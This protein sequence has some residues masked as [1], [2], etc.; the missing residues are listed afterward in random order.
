MHILLLK[1]TDALRLKAEDMSARVLTP[2]F[3]TGAFVSYKPVKDKYNQCVHSHE[4]TCTCMFTYSFIYYVF[5]L[6]VFH[7]VRLGHIWDGRGFI[8]KTNKKKN[9]PHQNLWQRQ[10]SNFRVMFLIQ[11]MILWIK[12]TFIHLYI[13]LF[14]VYASLSVDCFLP[15]MAFLNILSYFHIKWSAGRQHSWPTTHTLLCWLIH[16]TLS[17]TDANPHLM[18]AVVGG[19]GR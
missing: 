1:D 12:P 19:V 10:K 3:K 6:F 2:Q 17:E 14:N 15:L 5:C 9:L 4:H 11:S 8:P 7:S 18:V 16:G 13:Y